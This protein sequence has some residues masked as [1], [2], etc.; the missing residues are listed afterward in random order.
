MTDRS[1]DDL[2]LNLDDGAPAPAHRG[3]RLRVLAVVAVV[4]VL[5]GAL[6]FVA[7]RVTTIGAD[8]STTS[9]EAGFSRDM[10]THHRQGV[11]M[12]LLVY[13]STSAPDVRTLAYDITTT[14][15]V[16]TGKM[17]GWLE[18]WGLSP[19]SAE[20]EMTWM[21]TPGRSA[22]GHAHGTDGAAHVPGEPMPGLATPAQMAELTA[23]AVPETA[24]EADVLFLQLMIAH[25]RGAVD[26]AVALLDRSSH[27]VVTSFSRGVVASQESE[28]ELMQTMLESRGQARA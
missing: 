12:A 11:E 27:P 23:R 10:Q 7:G 20:P 4:A 19:Y 1:G 22:G 3:G 6:A 9:A 25:H 8:P 17:A 21:T 24:A 15:G 5:V 16:Q 2:D 28:I 26:M 13:A 18:L 14:Q